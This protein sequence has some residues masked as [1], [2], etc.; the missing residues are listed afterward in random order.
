MGEAGR[1]ALLVGFDRMVK[2]EFRGATISSDAGLLPYRDLDDAVQLTESAAAELLDLRIGRNIR[3]G[4][5]ALLR[6]SIYSP[7][8][9]YQDVNDSDRL[10]IDPVMRQVAGGRAV[11]HDAAS[12]SQVGRFETKVLGHLDNLARLMAMPGAWVDRVRQRRPMRTLI[13]DL[14]SSVSVTHGGQEGRRPPI[15]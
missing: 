6:Q 8:A 2:L 13:L 4:I 11:T 15:L 1:D 7:V 12:T 9:G 14:D 5:T 10:G 3:H